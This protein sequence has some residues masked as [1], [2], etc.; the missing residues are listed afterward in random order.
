MKTSKI[1]VNFSKLTDGQLE[2]LAMAVAA[3]MKGNTNF[4]EPSPAL[5]DLN[6]GIQLFS[7]G[8][9]LSKTRDKVKVAVKN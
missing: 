1:R 4:P 5:A 9:A 6:N 3:A 8:L 7:D 2:D